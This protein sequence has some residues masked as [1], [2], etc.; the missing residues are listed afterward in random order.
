VRYPPLSPKLLKVFNLNR[1]S[2]YQALR[3]RGFRGKV[4]DSKGLSVQGKGLYFVAG[5]VFVVAAWM[6]V[7]VGAG[8]FFEEV[9]ILDGAAD[10]VVAAGPLAEVKDAAA[11]GAEGEVG[12]RG[13]DDFAAGRAEEGFGH[14]SY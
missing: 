4:F 8:Q 6:A 7:G 9:G 3:N 12:V 10:L 11:V 2:V 13:E 14:G 1:L 5:L